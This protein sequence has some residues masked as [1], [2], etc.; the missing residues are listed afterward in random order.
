MGVHLPNV[1][2]ERVHRSVEAALADY[3]ERG[4]TQEELDRARNRI[5]L[6]ERRRRQSVHGIARE[7]GEAWTD[8]Q[9]AVDVT[10][11]CQ[12]VIESRDRYAL[13]SPWSFRRRLCSLYW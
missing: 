13:V 8:I 12:G 10:V 4:L 1:S 5:L 11:G 7:I 9:D 3:L 2:P 6:S